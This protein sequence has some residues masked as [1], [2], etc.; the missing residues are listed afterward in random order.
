MNWLREGRSKAGAHQRGLGGRRERHWRDEED[1]EESDDITRSG[2]F[3]EAVNAALLANQ[4]PLPS[5]GGFWDSP[6]QESPRPLRSILRRPRDGER[7][8]PP[9]PPPKPSLASTPPRKRKRAPEKDT[10]FTGAE[11]AFLATSPGPSATSR[12]SR[13]SSVSFKGGG[14][15]KVAAKRNSNGVSRSSSSEA[16]GQLEWELAGVGSRD[17]I[18]SHPGWLLTASRTT[19]ISGGAYRLVPTGLRLRLPPDS[20][21]VLH[22][23]LEGTLAERRVIFAQSGAVL[24]GGGGEGPLELLLHNLRPATA[25]VACGTPI[26]LLILHRTPHYS[27]SSE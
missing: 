17:P 27:I 12:N 3:D 13:N 6:G 8:E 5:S 23:R 2:F 21:G 18:F 7:K 25:V 14:S 22:D 1:E 20:Y 4:T 16:E 26:A 10:P 15:T 24:S 9:P 11:D 19:E